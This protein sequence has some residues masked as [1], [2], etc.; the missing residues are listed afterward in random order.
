MGE[1]IGLEATVKS[2]KLFP[3]EPGHWGY[4]SFTNPDHKIKPTTSIQPVKECNS[5]HEDHADQDWVFVQYYP[6]LRGALKK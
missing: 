4:F 5:C 6:V 2:A 1:F 3:K